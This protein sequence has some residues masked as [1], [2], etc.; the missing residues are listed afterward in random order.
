MIVPNK[1][2]SFDKSVLSKLHLVLDADFEYISISELFL[3]TSKYFEDVSEFIFSLDVLYVLGKI[4]FDR[5]TGILKK[6]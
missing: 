1:F 5:K 2:I 3:K 6:C 4:E